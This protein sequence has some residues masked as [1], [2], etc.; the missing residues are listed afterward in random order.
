MAEPIETESRL[1]TARSGEMV[2][3]GQKVPKIYCNF[4]QNRKKKHPKCILHPQDNEQ[5]NCDLLIQRNTSQQLT[6]NK[7]N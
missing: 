2:E 4:A 3:N 6:T 5:T 1:V 7:G